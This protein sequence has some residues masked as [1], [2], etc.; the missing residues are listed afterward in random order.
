ML[1]VEESYRLCRELFANSY[2]TCNHG[3]Q[4]LENI[5]NL[6]FFQLISVLHLSRHQG[7]G[8]PAKY[9]SSSCSCDFRSELSEKRCCNTWTPGRHFFVFWGQLV[10][11]TALPMETSQEN[12]KGGETE[13]RRWG[14]ETWTVVSN[15][16]QWSTG[17]VRRSAIWPTRHSDVTVGAISTVSTHEIIAC[18]SHIT[19][20]HFF[21]DLLAS[22]LF[23]FTFVTQCNS[24]IPSCLRAAW[25]QRTHGFLPNIPV[26]A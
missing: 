2:L 19:I 8:I 15:E 14:A 1:I 16:G 23:L 24:S 11:D 17:V 18:S 21:Q 26:A 6:Y 22:L 10:L 5:R 25:Y 9:I 13:E 4:R 3:F 12:G 20:A 7:G